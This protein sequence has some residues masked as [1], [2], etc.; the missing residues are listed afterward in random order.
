MDY[1]EECLVGNGYLRCLC[2]QLLIPKNKNMV[3]DLSNSFCYENTLCR[4]T[5]EDEKRVLYFTLFLGKL[6]QACFT[7]RPPGEGGLSD[8]AELMLKRRV[9]PAL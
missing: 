5:F 7:L 4:N 6:P 3:L 8:S 1:L 9:R 2:R